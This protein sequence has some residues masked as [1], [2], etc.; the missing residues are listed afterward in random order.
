V[1]V[2]HGLRTFDVTPLSIGAIPK[3]VLTVAYGQPSDPPTF[4]AY[5]QSTHVPLAKS[6]PGL[7]NLTARHCASLDDQQPPYY[8][9]VR[10][11]RLS[12]LNA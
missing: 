2:V 10:P 9:L 3:H 12:Q 6:V 11:A 8:L 7:V 5:Y 4:D 1:S